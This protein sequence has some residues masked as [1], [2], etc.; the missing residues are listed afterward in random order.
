[1]TTVF[2]TISL[3]IHL[4]RVQID[5]NVAELLQ[6]KEATCHGL[7]SGYRITL[8]TAGTDDL[9][10]LL[11]LSK[12]FFVVFALAVHRVHCTFDTVFC[13]R[14]WFFVANEIEGFFDFIIFQIVDGQIDHGFW[15][16][17]EQARQDLLGS[18]AV[19]EDDQVVVY[20]LSAK[21]IREI[22]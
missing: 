20:E 7:A 5:Q 17:V 4:D 15:D 2:S 9:K 10:I 11:G 22:I 6:Q 21:A 18:F 19:L 16:Y 1:M 13:W 3:K 14:L 12:K 8:C